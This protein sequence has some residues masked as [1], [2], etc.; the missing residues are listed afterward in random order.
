M[1]SRSATTTGFRCPS[2]TD[3]SLA[4]RVIAAECELRGWRSQRDYTCCAGRDRPVRSALLQQRAANHRCAPGMAHSGRE[5][6]SSL[7]TSVE[8][9]DAVVLARS[10]LVDPL[11]IHY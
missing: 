3:S 4:N 2:Y 7:G 10:W 8:K 11:A 9:P 1:V 6:G 5:P